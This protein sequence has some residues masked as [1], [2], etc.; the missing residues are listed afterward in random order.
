VSAFGY[1]FLTLRVRIASAVDAQQ[2][3]FTFCHNSK[4][5]AGINKRDEFDRA[6]Q[7]NKF[8]AARPDV[9]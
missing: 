6:G 2:Q 7:C 5:F 8:F 9:I 3:V 4:C 1:Y